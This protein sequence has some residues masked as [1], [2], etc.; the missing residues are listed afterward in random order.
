MSVYLSICVSHFFVHHCWGCWLGIIVSY[1]ISLIRSKFIIQL[2]LLLYIVIISSVSSDAQ[3]CLTLWDPMDG[4]TLGLPVQHQLLELSQIYV[5]WVGD[6]IKPSYPPPSPSPPAFNLSQHQGLLHWVSSSHQVAKVL[7]FQLQ[8]PSFQ[9]IFRT[10][11]LWD[12]WLDLLAVWGTLRSLLQH[13]SSKASI[14]WRSAFFI[15]QISHPYMT[16]WQSNVSAF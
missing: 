3:S 16:T 14:L 11:F 4:S 15:V 5:H 10:D 2:H 12:D 6:A 7:E 8:H 1:F 13:H 9:W